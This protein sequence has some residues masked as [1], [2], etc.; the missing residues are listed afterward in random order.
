MILTW[1]IDITYYLFFIDNNYCAFDAQRQNIHLIFIFVSLSIS[2]SVSSF[3]SVV[4]LCQGAC[5]V[6]EEKKLQL[7]QQTK[8]AIVDT[9]TYISK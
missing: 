7:Q 9:H 4:Q 3:F 2:L 1:R 6:G 5:L 8:K